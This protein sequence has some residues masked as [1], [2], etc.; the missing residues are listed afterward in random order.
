MAFVYSDRVKEQSSSIGFT[1]MVLSGALA[2]FQDFAAGI[3]DTN[4]TYYTIVNDVDNTWEVG[5]GTYTLGSN[6]LSRDT[7]LASSNSNNP[8][9][10]AAG[11]K[12]VFSTV[13]AQFF[14]AVLTASTHST[15]NHTGILGVPAAEIFTSGNHALTDHSGIPG[16]G[17]V[18]QRFY[19]QQGAFIDI[20][21]G[22]LIPADGTIPQDTEGSFVVSVGITP[23]KI[24][25]KISVRAQIQWSGLNNSG[26]YT[27]ALFEAGSV[28]AIAATGLVRGSPNMKTTTV[29]GEYTATALTALTFSVRH[30]PD[31]GGG[32]PSIN[33]DDSGAP[34]QV[35]G[36]VAGTWIEVIEYYV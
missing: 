17:Y 15:L 3:G 33:G 7:V 28:N 21:G 29:A 10:F 1:S 35:Y 2:G 4:Q 5:R 8:V 34:A 12:T 31:I 6:S 19:A 20:T 11:S 16:V 18:V 25:N 36:G 32:S 26:V 13:A 14:G 22:P 24:G 27:S 23:K 30:G 9:N